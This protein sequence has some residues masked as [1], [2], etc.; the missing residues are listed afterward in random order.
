MCRPGVPLA[1]KVKIAEAGKFLVGVKSTTGVT[2]RKTVVIEPPS[3]QAGRFNFDFSGDIRPGKEF[4]ITAKVSDPL[5][6]QTLTL[7]LPKALQ[8]AKGEV[9]QPVGSGKESTVSWSVRVAESGRLPVRIE[10]STGLVR[11]KTITLSE[12]TLFGR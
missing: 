4:T 3:D 11:T 12:N 7:A 2:Q 8:L 6:G 5:A 10:S 9:T 1:W